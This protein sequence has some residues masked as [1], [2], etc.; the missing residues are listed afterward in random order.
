[1]KK[2]FVL[3]L[4]TIPFITFAQSKRAFKKEIKKFRKH[5]KQEFLEEARSPFYNNKKGMKNMRFY[6]PKREYKL[7]ANFRRTPNAETFKMATYSGKTQDYVLYGVATVMLH[8][9][10]LEVN[11]YQS[12]RLRDMEEYKDHLFIPFKDLTNDDITYGGGRY[13]DMKMSDI[14]N[15]TVTID[16]NR[17]YNPWCAFS[18]G[19]NCPVPPNENH[20]DLEIEA[21]EKMFA[22]KH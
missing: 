6:K 1:M 19:Y 2:I 10:K 22:G 9:K 15:G 4:L 12:L 8:G 21:G 18:D 17:C 3:L 5:Y 16:F 7:K 13:M 11:I 14:K 20:F